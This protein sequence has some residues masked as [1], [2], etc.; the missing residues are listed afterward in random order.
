MKRGTCIALTATGVRAGKPCWSQEPHPRLSDFCLW[1]GRILEAGKA[2]KTKKGPIR[3][4]DLKS[5]PPESSTTADR[6]AVLPL[7]PPENA[8]EPAR[9]PGSAGPAAA[10][11]RD[12]PRR[13]PGRPRKERLEDDAGPEAEPAAQAVNASDANL[14]ALDRLAE[15]I[16][17]DP[18]SGAGEIETEAAELDPEIRERF[19]AAAP[20]RPSSGGSPFAGRWDRERTA[21]VLKLADLR[22]EADGKDRLSPLELDTWAEAMAPVFDDLFG[23]LNPENKYVA[24]TLATG[25]VILPRYGAEMWE[26]A[27]KM[28]GRRRLASSSPLASSEDEITARRAA[29]TSWWG[30]AAGG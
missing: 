1:H 11:P 3:L 18:E 15:D 22:L 25:A 16:W 9:R 7:A 13:K 10:P 5:G 26:W 30:T 12:A 20:A 27:R 2:I 6:R 29:G 14:E 17:A 19:E 23:R 4:E 28:G 21:A 8:P 24:A